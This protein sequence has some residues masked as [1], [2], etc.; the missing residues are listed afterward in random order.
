ML[1]KF[2]FTTYLR[3]KH[4]YPLGAGLGNGRKRVGGDGGGGGGRI[5]NDDR[6]RAQQIHFTHHKCL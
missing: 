6:H 3:L 4:T 5:I 1:R 2:T